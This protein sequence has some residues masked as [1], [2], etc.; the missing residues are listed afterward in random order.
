[1]QPM[2]SHAA[3]VFLAPIPE[4]KIFCSESAK[5]LF[6]FSGLY[7]EYVRPENQKVC[8]FC[9]VLNQ[10][11]LTSILVRTFKYMILLLQQGYCWTV[12]KPHCFHPPWSLPCGSWN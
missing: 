4:S 10:L 7:S 8:F 9:I 5:L 1:M 2:G 3:H 11:E 12:R 6:S